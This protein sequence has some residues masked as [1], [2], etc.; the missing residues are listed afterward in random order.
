M[1]KF[2]FAQFGIQFGMWDSFIETIMTSGLKCIQRR[3]VF[4]EIV[5]FLINKTF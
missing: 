4:C 3:I 1:E 2:P 5:V